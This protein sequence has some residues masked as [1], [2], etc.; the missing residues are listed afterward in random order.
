MKEVPLLIKEQSSCVRKVASLVLGKE[1]SIDNGFTMKTP[2]SFIG[3]NV[4]KRDNEFEASLL[5]GFNIYLNKFR[6]SSSKSNIPMG[7]V[8]NRSSNEESSGKVDLNDSYKTLNAFLKSVE[9]RFDTNNLVG[10]EVASG[11]NKPP[12]KPRSK[13]PNIKVDILNGESFLLEDG[14]SI[15]FDESN[16]VSNTNK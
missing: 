12:I 14:V 11:L 5:L 8:D 10:V 6:D 1:K 13:C 3:F 16:E 7:N 15:K 2:C 4:I 9:G